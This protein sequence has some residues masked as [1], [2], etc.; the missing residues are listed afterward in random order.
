MRLDGIAPNI[1]MFIFDWNGTLLNDWDLS[2]GAIET[3]FASFGLKAPTREVARREIGANYMEF[4]FRHGIP[5]PKSE[6]YLPAIKNH[7]NQIRNAYLSERWEDAKLA[8]GAEDILRTL[9]DR[10]AL[11]AIVSAENSEILRARLIQFQIRS[12]FD[13]VTSVTSG[14]NEKFNALK[15]TAY[16]FGLEPKNC[17]YTDDTNDGILSAKLAGMKTIGVLGGYNNDDFVLAAHADIT[18]PA[19]GK[20]KEILA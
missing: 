13:H 10:K 7:L 9:S 8:E 3:I 16:S 17:V 12:Y 5:R 19:L 4:Y 20:M 2:Y 14:K 15:S 18:I 1:R 6:E 11:T